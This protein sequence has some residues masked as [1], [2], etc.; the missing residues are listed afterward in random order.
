M[1]D[2][3]RNRIE[4]RKREPHFAVLVLAE[5]VDVA[6]ESLDRFILASCHA[7]GSVEQECYQG[8]FVSCL[9]SRLR[10]CFLY[11]VHTNSG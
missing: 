10:F 7:A 1:D 4:L 8:W 6:V 5:F 9:F 11:F 2:V 3:N